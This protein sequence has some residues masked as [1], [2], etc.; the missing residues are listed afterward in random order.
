MLSC[1]FTFRKIYI[2]C[3]VKRSLGVVVLVVWHAFILL[4]DASA[5]ECDFVSGDFNLK[6]ELFEVWIHFKDHQN[7]NTYQY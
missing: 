4:A 7:S 3:D 5:R 6:T 2:E 1:Q